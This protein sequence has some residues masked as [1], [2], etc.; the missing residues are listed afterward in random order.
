M[1]SSLS[2]ILSNIYIKQF[3]H[4]AMQTYDLQPKLWLRYIDDTFVIWPHPIHTLQ[5]YLAHIDNIKPSIKFTMELEEED[6]EK[7][8]S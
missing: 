2:A 4:T 8:Y 6:L 7:F 5:D 3:K 1:R